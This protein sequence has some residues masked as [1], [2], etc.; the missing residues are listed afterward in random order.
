MY[1]LPTRM[2]RNQA[3][4]GMMMAALALGALGAG[5]FMI[6][7]MFLKN[8]EVLLK[9]SRVLAYRHLVDSVRKNLYAGN[10]CTVALGSALTTPGAGR[11]VA[12]A[13]SIPAG[14]AGPTGEPIPMMEMKLGAGNDIIKL[15]P[16]MKLKTG[17]SIKAIYIQKWKNGRHDDTIRLHPEVGAP[18]DLKAGYFRIIIEPDHKGINIWKKDK[19]PDGTFKYVH[20][21]F[22][23]NIYAYYSDSTKQI[24]SCYDPASDATYCTEIQKGAFDH[25][26]TGSL[27]VITAEMRCQPDRVCFQ[28]KGGIQPE[29]SPCP[30]P[31]LSSSIGGG[32]TIAG[33]G[34]LQMCSWCHPVPLAFANSDTGLAGPN[35]NLVAGGDDTA[36]ASCTASG[37]NGDQMGS[38]YLQNDGADGSLLAGNGS[39]DPNVAADAQNCA[40]VNVNC[41]DDTR[42]GPGGPLGTGPYPEYEGGLD[43]NRCVND[44]NGS[45]R[46]DYGGGCNNGT[47]CN[48]DNPATQCDNECTGGR[49]VVY[50]GCDDICTPENECPPPDPEP[51]CGCF[52]AGTQITMSDGRVKTIEDVL[53]AEKIVDGAFNVQNVEKT[54]KIPYKGKVYGIN[55][56]R[57]FFTPN[58]PFMTVSGWKSLNPE[59]SRKDIPGVEFGLLRLGDILVTKSGFEVIYSMDHI[60]VDDFVYNLSISNSHEY[61]ADEYLVHNI[62][63]KLPCM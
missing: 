26:A 51:Q 40:S 32:D 17:T 57:H 58:H 4:A 38:F 55:G 14:S 29:G 34:R 9:D 46:T 35:F 37:F 61:Y 33:S 41:A 36:G 23:I 10:A 45:A 18:A 20:E 52:L 6:G 22:F 28:Y 56:G 48:F 30:L 50:D 49:Y 12:G 5:A 43:G 31:Y 27:G 54:W 62:Q 8:D 53:K 39:G 63:E 25:R 16:D 59:A 7:D 11:S 19:Q 15:A 2:I 47:P 42:V 13:L 44:C 24:Y 3:G 1:V 21:S 60:E